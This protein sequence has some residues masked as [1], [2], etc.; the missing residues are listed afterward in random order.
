MKRLRLPGGSE[1]EMLLSYYFFLEELNQLASIAVM[2]G[3]SNG[4][5]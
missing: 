5:E 1:T 4:G 3:K 2:P